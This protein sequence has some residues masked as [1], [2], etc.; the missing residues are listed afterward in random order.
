MADMSTELRSGYDTFL[1]LAKQMHALTPPPGSREIRGITIE[2][3]SI[4][5]QIHEAMLRMINNPKNERVFNDAYEDFI[6]FSDTSVT[7]VLKLHDAA[8]ELCQ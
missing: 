1:L 3:A 7:V 4:A 2:Y 5:E 6:R 8:L